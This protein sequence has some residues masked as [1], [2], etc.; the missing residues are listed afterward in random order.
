MNFR[1]GTRRLALL[2]G[3]VGAILGG[4]ASYA[5]LGSAQAQST[6]HAEFQRLTAGFANSG[7]AQR[8][9]QDAEHDPSDNSIM[10]GCCG[11]EEIVWDKNHVFNDPSGVYSITTDGGQTVYATPAPA[12]WTYLLIPLF[13]VIGFFIPWGT[14]RSIGWVGTGFSQ[15][16]E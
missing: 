16:P 14:I 10:P 15:P 1:E 11:I 4:F 12:V 6:R 3:V 8:M 5:E 9:R 13:P 2:L 7:L